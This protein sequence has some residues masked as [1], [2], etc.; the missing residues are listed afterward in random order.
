MKKL[1]ALIIAIPFVQFAQTDSF[2]VSD[3]V[4]GDAFLVVRLENGDA[5]VKNFENTSLIKAYS[6]EGL[7]QFVKSLRAKNPEVDRSFKEI[8]EAIDRIKEKAGGSLYGFGNAIFAMTATKDAKEATA[9]FAFDLKGNK[10]AEESI[11]KE[12]SQQQK[13]KTR[14]NGIEFTEIDGGA[15]YGMVGSCFVISNSKVWLEQ[16]TGKDASARHVSKVCYSSWK[17]FPVKSGS[18]V[19]WLDFPKLFAAIP[20]GEGEGKQLLDAIKNAGLTGFTISIETEGNKIVSRGLVGWGKDQFR[21]PVTSDLFKKSLRDVR[22]EQGVLAAEFSCTKLGEMMSSLFKTMTQK[23]KQWNALM[24]EAGL[25]I[26]VAEFPI[27]NLAAYAGEIESV[28]FLTNEGFA[29]VNRSDLGIPGNMFSVSGL[30]VVSAIAIPGI[31]SA[32]RA[33]NERNA[34]A[35]LKQIVN[36]QVVFRA[37]HGDY[38]VGDVSG[39]VRLGILPDN[40]LAAADAN[41]LPSGKEKGGLDLGN[42]PVLKIPKAGYYFMVMKSFETD[43]LTLEDYNKDGNNR[44]PTRFA[45]VAYP[46]NYP[47]SGRFTFIINESGNVYQKDTYGEIPDKFPSDPYSEGWYP[48]Y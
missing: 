45:I 32:Q 40:A 9:Y 14:I 18:L 27:A 34:A 28:S 8:A 5:F 3:W 17:Q 43:K 2:T 25:E 4:P 7:S 1:I 11:I 35:T 38:W 20:E 42:A 15:F 47:S 10:K 36:A 30:A 26:D 16:A 29:F 33:S 31:L 21:Y 6:D 48:I 37:T 13:G 12:I 39:L 19:F 23:A 46:A 44:N 41:P 22:T 24:K